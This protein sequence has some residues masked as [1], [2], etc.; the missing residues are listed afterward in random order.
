MKV[1]FS[2]TPET[3]K[4]YREFAARAAEFGATHLSVNPWNSLPR[5]Y[6]EWDINRNDPYPG[7][8][9]MCSGFFKNVGVE[10]LEEWIPADYSRRCLELIAQRGDVLREFGLKGTFNT[11]EPYSLPE[12]VFLAHPEWRGP[13][14]DAPRR[15]KR[16]YYSPCIDHPEVLALYR[17]VIT[18]LC[19]AA[20]IDLITMG[21]NDCGAGV[22]WSAG[23]YP[24]ANG[25]SHCE[26]RSMSDRIS[27]FLSAL[28][29]G[30]SAAGQTA[31]VWLSGLRRRH[32][33]KGV[34]PLLK[35]GQY[36]DGH[37]A[38]MKAP[39]GAGAGDSIDYSGVFPVRGLMQPVKFLR[40]L[41]GVTAKADMV[42]Y[43]FPTT[44]DT[45]LFELLRLNR[46]K[47]VHN[48]W[49]VACR[50]HEFAAA[51]GGP[52][53]A[54]ALYEMWQAVD[55]AVQELGL[56]GDGGPVTL[57]GTVNQR[58]LNRPFVAFPLELTAAEKDYYR[59]FQFQ[60]RSEEKA[61]D[62]MNFQD[63]TQVK[64]RSGTWLATLSLEKAM[65]QVQKAIGRAQ[66]ILAAMPKGAFHDEMRMNELRLRALLCVV[67]NLHNACAYQGVLDRTDYA[68]TPPVEEC[69]WDGLGD[70]RGY[71]LRTIARKEIDN[72]NELADLIDQAPEPLLWLAGTPEEEDIF[73]FGPDLAK[74]LRKKAKIMLDHEADL[75]RLYAM[76][77][78]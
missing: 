21:T 7:W 29:E 67:R 17:K 60:A 54:A 56:I 68:V 12:G 45:D 53:H 77:N 23:L 20:P 40:G 18:K 26:N 37:G 27:G 41:T 15:A 16:P 10:E 78:P 34:S 43:G 9:I 66:G 4:D 65:S 75:D 59:P 62:L 19:K 44:K 52:A 2:A 6:W 48:E 38:N 69:Y 14:T 13:R 30:A 47:P 49:D 74:Q 35:A 28:Q 72:C 22:C 25:P 42:S 57:C 33:F 32:E 31:E 73:R 70:L 58:L 3:L 39:R 55:S 71:E 1:I 36:V 24:L 8:T 51:K 63:M 61:A 50:L 5:S 46:E 11:N 76:P 64:G